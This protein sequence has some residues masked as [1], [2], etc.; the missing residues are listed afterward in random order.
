MSPTS[1]P[2]DSRLPL[3]ST[4]PSQYRPTPPFG[5]MS[6][7]AVTGSSLETIERARRVTAAERF[8]IGTRFPAVFHSAEGSWMHD[9]EGGRVLDVTA[10][11][12][13]LLLGNR[14]PAVVEAVVRSVRDH[15]T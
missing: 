8:D 11:S 12:G 7:V 5:R 13:A 2:R 6:M 4:A 9:L 15:G 1:A 3:F 10:A 14:H